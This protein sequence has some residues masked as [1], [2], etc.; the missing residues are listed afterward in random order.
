M[1]GC[2]EEPT[3]IMDSDA[4]HSRSGMVGGHHGR[5][6]VAF[7]FLAMALALTACDADPRNRLIPHVTKPVPGSDQ[8]YPSLVS[9]P[10][11][12]PEVTPKSQRLILSQELA[13]DNASGSYVP[14]ASTPPTIPA[15]PPALPQGFTSAERPVRIAEAPPSSALEATL[16]SGASRSDARGRPSRVAIVLFGE[17]SSAIDPGEVK[18]LEPVVQMLRRKGGILQVVGYAASRTGVAD[19]ARDKMANL[20]L[21]LDRANAVARVLRRLGVRPTELIVTAEGNNA[22]LASIEG[23][24][25]QAAKERADVYL[26]H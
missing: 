12:A 20:D 7:A 1:A 2:E 25:G 24:N 5:R 19:S 23:V 3:V 11:K 22:P 26:E 13:A 8:P 10:D 9:V 14:D 16:P 18:A 15:P 6:V 4:A 21:S 17:G